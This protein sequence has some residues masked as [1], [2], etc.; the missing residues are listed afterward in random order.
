MISEL[1]QLVFRL[2]S[3]KLSKLVQPVI[4]LES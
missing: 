4:R 3:Y 1:V 2:E